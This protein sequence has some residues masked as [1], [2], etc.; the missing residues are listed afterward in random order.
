MGVGND[1]SPSSLWDTQL[2]L[3]SHVCRPVSAARVSPGL[4]LGQPVQHLCVLVSLVFSDGGRDQEDDGTGPALLLPDLK[5]G[6][7]KRLLAL[8]Y[9]SCI[10]TLHKWQA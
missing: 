8:S 6:R 9:F 7:G 1:R 3:H 4:S 5:A 2:G 10:C